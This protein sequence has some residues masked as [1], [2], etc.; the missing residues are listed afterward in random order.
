MTRPEFATGLLP[1]PDSGEVPLAY[2]IGPHLAG[3]HPSRT[4]HAT[5]KDGERCRQW[6]F[7]RD[8]FCGHHDPLRRDKVE[9]SLRRAREKRWARHRER[10]RQAAEVAALPVAGSGMPERPPRTL[11]EAA[12]WSA[13]AAYAVATGV[14]STNAARCITRAC[15]VFTK[16][17]Q[18]AR[19]ERGR[20]AVR[21]RLRA[22]AGTLP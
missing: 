14:I 20:R 17:A 13:W 11:A 1:I 10:Q 12:T 2:S 18:L 15:D 8:G 16:A 22:A 19:A 4:C 21:Q 9:E 6:K 3:E 5:R 7:L